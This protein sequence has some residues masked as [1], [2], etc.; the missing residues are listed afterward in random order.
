MTVLRNPVA[1]RLGKL[2][3]TG[4]TGAL[5]LSGESGGV[6]HLE[7]GDIVLADSRA[8]P[9]LRSRIERAEELAGQKALGVFE[10]CWITREATIDACT[11]LFSVKP[12]YVRF[13]EL[14]NRS[15]GDGADSTSVAE[16]VAEISRRHAL[17]GQLS[18]VLGPD[19]LVAR[20]P[21]L[22]SRAIQVSDIQWDI[23]MRL[24]D[25][26]PARG[27]A[28]ELGQSVFG[29]TIEVFRMAVM[30]LVSV[31]GAQAGADDEA[32]ESSWRKPAMSF[33][34]SLAG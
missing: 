5:Y 17:L 21:R 30:D 33:L 2:A 32:G 9:S 28:H 29:T 34:H 14:E 20:K 7:K 23:L 22:K 25:P 12:R 16:L 19:T 8:T 1:V 3:D 4:K 18:A 26:A 31:D 24:N 11:E 6:I 15:A 13:R 27:L 10:R